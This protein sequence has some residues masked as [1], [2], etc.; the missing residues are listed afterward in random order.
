VDLEVLA[1]GEIPDD[2]CGVCMI[3]EGVYIAIAKAG[4]E[5]GAL[6]VCDKCA[7]LVKERMMKRPKGLP[8]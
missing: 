3:E 4:G 6:F 2:F 5:Y 1:M 8:N 7:G